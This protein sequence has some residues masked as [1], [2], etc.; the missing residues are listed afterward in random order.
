MGK[1][2]GIHTWWWELMGTE[3]QQATTG[4]AK[5]MSEWVGSS[6]NV[7]DLSQWGQRRWWFYGL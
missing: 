2:P 1:V 6:K 5:W 7:Q 3:V 4:N